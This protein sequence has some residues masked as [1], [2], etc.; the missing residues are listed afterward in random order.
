MAK[1]KDCI[2]FP[3]CE[4]YTDPN[5]SYPEVGGCSAFKGKDAFVEVVRCK[6]CE[7]CQK[8]PA[9]YFCYDPRDKYTDSVEVKEDDFCSYGERREGE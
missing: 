6:D 2:H 5:E 9:G 4:P 8:Y 7:Y 1:C 3:I